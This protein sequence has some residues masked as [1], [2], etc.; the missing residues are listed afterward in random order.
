M[1]DP[2][3]DRARAR[4]RA[5]GT[6]AVVIYTSPL[7]GAVLAAYCC[8]HFLDATDV[9][10]GAICSWVRVGRVNCPAQGP[11]VTGQE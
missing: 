3:A 1:T 4:C 7:G 10:C 6:V 11:G 2:F 9:P 5:C 8:R